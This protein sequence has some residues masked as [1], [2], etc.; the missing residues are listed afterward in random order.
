MKQYLK[1][2]SSQC[3]QAQIFTDLWKGAKICKIPNS[4]I[5]TPVRPSLLPYRWQAGYTAIKLGLYR[6]AA[7]VKHVFKN[8]L[9]QHSGPSGYL[10][11]KDQ[12]A[13]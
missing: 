2:I 4:N 13:S 10:K 11:L 7:Q 9:E 5:K 6:C 8:G 1:F 12:N 3:C